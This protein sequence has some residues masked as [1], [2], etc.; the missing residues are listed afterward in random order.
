MVQDKTDPVG[1]CPYCGKQIKEESATVYIGGETCAVFCSAEC[2]S[3]SFRKNLR[4]LYTMN[5]CVVC[6][7]RKA[8]GRFIKP[9]ERFPEIEK[10]S[11]LCSKKCED[12]FFRRIISARKKNRR[13]QL[14]L[15]TEKATDDDHSFMWNTLTSKEQKLLAMIGFGYIIMHSDH[16]PADFYKKLRL[17]MEESK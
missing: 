3:L 9:D 5:K 12:T 15:K 14:E 8:S 13:K 4:K 17:K 6:G 16:T 1:L 2:M 7:K 10:E 11:F